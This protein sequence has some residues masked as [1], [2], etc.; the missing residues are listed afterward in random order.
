MTIWLF[1]KQQLDSFSTQLANL[2][3]KNEKKSD[4]LRAA[5]EG[6]LTQL[7]SDNA[8]KLEEMRRTVDEKLQGTLDKRLGE[9]FK[10]R[11]RPP[12][13]GSQGPGRNAIAR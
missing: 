8:S 1:Q 13:A 2:M 11:K 4:E 12:G 7:Q 10:H 3:E 6:K 5:V 9:S